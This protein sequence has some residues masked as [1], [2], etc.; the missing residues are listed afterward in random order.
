MVMVMQIR[1][2]VYLT[3]NIYVHVRRFFEIC[4]AC[5]DTDTV[6]SH[7]FCDKINKCY[8]SYCN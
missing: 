4:A 1:R 6:Y 7:S 3:Y 2:Y 5:C 8:I